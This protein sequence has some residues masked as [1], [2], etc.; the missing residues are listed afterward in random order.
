MLGDRL[1]PV[2]LPD[3]AEGLRHIQTCL[4]VN[5]EHVSSGS[6]SE[7][8]EG[9]PLHAAAWTANH[10]NARGLA[11]QAGQLVATGQTCIYRGA[12][13]GDSVVADF[14]LRSGELLGRVR[15]TIS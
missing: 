1:R 5:G 6:T 9:G 4:Y 3:P 8:P 2:E 10:L 11:L 12:E 7:C 14:F 13:P 15:V